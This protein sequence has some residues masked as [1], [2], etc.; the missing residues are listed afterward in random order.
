MNAIGINDAFHRLVK[1]GM[2]AEQAWKKLTAAL[3]SGDL[4]AVVQRQ[5]GRA[6]LR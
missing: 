4:K 1:D 6:R 2:T 5:S 3:M